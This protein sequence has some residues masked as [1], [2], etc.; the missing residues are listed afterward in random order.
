[1]VYSKDQR[2]PPPAGVGHEEEAGP[3]GHRHT[4]ALMACWQHSAT[5][6]P[7]RPMVSPSRPDRTRP[8]LSNHPRS[9]IGFTLCCRAAEHPSPGEINGLINVQDCLRLRVIYLHKV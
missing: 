8:R 5:G 2:G 6:A 3:I 4:R 9:A 1:M 7:S